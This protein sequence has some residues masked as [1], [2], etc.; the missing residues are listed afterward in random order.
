MEHLKPCRAWASF[1]DSEELRE[2]GLWERDG[3]KNRTFFMLMTDDANASF[4]AEM[5]G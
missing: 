4:F 2:S 3:K 1:I 5:E